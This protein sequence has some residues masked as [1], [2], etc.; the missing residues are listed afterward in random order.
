MWTS[1]KPAN[2]PTWRSVFVA[3][4]LGSAALACVAAAGA[5]SIHTKTARTLNVTDEAHLHLVNTAGEVLEEEGPATGALP[6][7][8]HVRFTVGSSVTGT[9]VFYPRG[10]GSITGHGSARLHSTG[11]NASFGG[12]LSVSQGTGRYA[13]AHGRGGLYG[14]V[15]RRT[16]A[17]TLQTTGKLAY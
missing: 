8:V 14:V 9:F 1:P 12:D 5:S 6:G 3:T 7:K 17:M 4:L 2:L 15:D 13:R 16:D 11:T 10:G